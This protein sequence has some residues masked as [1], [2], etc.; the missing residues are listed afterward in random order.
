VSKAVDNDA[1]A[2]EQGDNDIVYLA[3]YNAFCMK[4]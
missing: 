3:D 4:K 1:S 2:L